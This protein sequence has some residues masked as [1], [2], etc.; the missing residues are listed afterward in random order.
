MEKPNDYKWV[1]MIFLAGD[2]NL[3]ENC[4]FSLR[5]MK[6]A[7]VIPD[8]AV[9]AQY[10]PF[11]VMQPI[12]TQRYVINAA[13][14]RKTPNPEGLILADLRGVLDETNTGAAETLAA[15][16]FWSVTNFRADHYMLVLWGHGSGTAE[17]FLLRDENPPDA[18]SIPELKDAFR[19]AKKRLEDVGLP[20]TVLGPEGKI[21]ILGMDSCLMSTGEVGY[22]VREHARYLVGSESFEANMGWPYKRIL[23]HLNEPKITPREFATLIVD[24]YVKFYFDF[25]ATGRSVDLGACDL[26][27]SERFR[28]AVKLLAAV[29]RRGLRFDRLKDAIVLAHWE[30]QGY[31]FDEYIDLFDFCAVLEARC[32]QIIKELQGQGTPRG[33]EAAHTAQ[34]LKKL[35]RKINEAC[36]AVRGVL[37]PGREPA[38]CEGLRRAPHAAGAAPTP[39]FILKSCFSGAQFQYSY[40]V[41]IY[42]PWARVSFNY[43]NLD[44]A[45]Q[46]GWNNFLREYVELTRRC[47]RK[48][49]EVVRE[50]PTKSKGPDDDKQGS[51]KNP[52]TR[53]FI[54]DCLHKLI[55]GDFDQ[56]QALLSRVQPNDDAPT[57]RPMTDHEADSPARHR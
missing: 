55:G 5:D 3:S 4:L 32:E 46:T 29:L 22:E 34:D 54:N 25:I 40:G 6:R 18:L 17:D 47:P 7:G 26:T 31:K 30:A 16:I 50:S 51:T 27:Q 24:E 36:R 42:F 14:R 56:A 35:A 45:D 57:D 19:L 1:V 37:L 10:D 2:N 41:S 39:P 44:F 49:S 33:K 48:D 38:D 11:E 20:E 8:T 9:L 13:A 12:P 52:P 43:G 28:E 21:D 23:P 15:F 53:W